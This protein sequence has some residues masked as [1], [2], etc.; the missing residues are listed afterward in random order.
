MKSIFWDVT[1]CSPVAGS[2]CRLVLAGFLTLRHWRFRNCS[3]ETSV[4]VPFTSLSQLNSFQS[5][6]LY[7]C[8]IRFNIILPSTPRYQRYVYLTSPMPAS[9]ITHHQPYSIWRSV[10]VQWL[11]R[12]LTKR[13]QISQMFSEFLTSK[14]RRTSG[15]EVNVAVESHFTNDPVLPDYLGLW[16]IRFMKNTINVAMNIRSL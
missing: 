5:F 11:E 3:S 12:V 13:K 2:A 6:T 15:G 10:R 1:P 9:W 16:C 7:V 14:T 4:I 8:K